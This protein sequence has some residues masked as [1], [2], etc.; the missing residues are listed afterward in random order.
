MSLMGSH[1]AR[2]LADDGMLG[3][4]STVIA[5]SSAVEFDEILVV[6]PGKH[7]LSRG[8]EVEAG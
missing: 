8:N 5:G 3:L 6:D 2:S 7:P 4:G 1:A